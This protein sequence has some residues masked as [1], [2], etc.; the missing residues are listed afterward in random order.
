M[1]VIDEVVG[2]AVEAF[3]RQ[4]IIGIFEKE[5]EIYA[6]QLDI[7]PSE[8][9]SYIHLHLRLGSTY[10]IQNR[11]VAVQPKKAEQVIEIFNQRV[12]FY[13]DV[14]PLLTKQTIEVVVEGH[15]KSKV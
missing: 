10:S 4:R 6:K 5:V 11:R 14:Y 15:L 8:I 9:R 1:G 7:R 13:S 2:K 3:G 12:K